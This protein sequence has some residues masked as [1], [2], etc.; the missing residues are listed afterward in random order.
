MRSHVLS[1]AQRMAEILVGGGGAILR[2]PGE[3]IFKTSQSVAKSI[4]SLFCFRK[5][6]KDN[7][8]QKEA[9]QN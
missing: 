1:R 7:R 8:T 3:L 4:H 6:A 9:G 2:L 5:K